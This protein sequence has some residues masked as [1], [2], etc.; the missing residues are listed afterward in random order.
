LVKVIDEV[1][2]GEKEDNVVASYAI[3]NK[4]CPVDILIKI[5]ERDK[6]DG[7]SEGAIKNPNCPA[8]LKIQYMRKYGKI[9]Q[10]DSNVHIIDKPEVEVDED[11]EQLKEMAK[12]E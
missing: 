6:C 2:S 9:T 12:G 7:L 1:L 4:N 8:D 3:E 10:E 11:L 5:L